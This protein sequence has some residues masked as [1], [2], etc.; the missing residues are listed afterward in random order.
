MYMLIN[1]GPF[2]L[3]KLMLHSVAT[4]LATSVLPVPV[5]NS[6]SAVSLCLCN[7]KFATIKYQAT[8]AQRCC[9]VSTAR[10]DAYE[11]P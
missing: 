3:K 4:A 9:S 1:S 2:T 8:P 10:H 6:Q 7:G 11:L 5:L